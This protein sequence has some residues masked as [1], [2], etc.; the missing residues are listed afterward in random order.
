MKGQIIILSAPSGGGKTTIIREVRARMGSLSYSVSHTSRKPRP[1]EQ[2]GIHYHFVRPQ[3]FEAMIERGEFVEWA[4][5]YG[6][7]YGTSKQALERE[8]QKGLDVL[9]DVD[10]VGARNIKE[11]YPD[12]ILI[13]VVP[14]SVQVLEHRLLARGT[15]SREAVKKRLEKAATEIKEAR[16]YDYVVIN[17]ALEEAVAD[18]I[19][20]VR[21]GR[22]RT[23]RKLSYLQKHFKI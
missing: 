3:E 19:G 22:C 1:G 6:D 11:K 10:P 12:A 4:R 2:D 16:Y 17:D 23:P 8:L 18:V 14:P 9:M 5:V 21:A 20:I 7:Y 13:F 15:D